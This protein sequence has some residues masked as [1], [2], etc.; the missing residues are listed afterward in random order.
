MTAIQWTG[1]EMYFCFATRSVQTRR[2]LMASG[3]EVD[4]GFER[5]YCSFNGFVI[6]NCFV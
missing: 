6:L 1:V 4:G 2:M 3:M 5:I